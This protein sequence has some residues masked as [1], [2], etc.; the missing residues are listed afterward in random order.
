V[1]P[2]KLGEPFYLQFFF[3]DKYLYYD[4][5]EG[6]FMLSS[7]EKTVFKIM[8][9]VKVV[10]YDSKASKKQQALD[11]IGKTIL[12]QERSNSMTFATTS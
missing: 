10:S 8:S 12:K 2:I 4:D 11:S 7:T 3:L 1:P 5:K 9:R 6:K